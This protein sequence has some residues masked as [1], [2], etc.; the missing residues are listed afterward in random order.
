ML[1]PTLTTYI[2]QIHGTNLSASLVYSA[3]AGA[4]LIARAVF[5]SLMDKIGRKPVLLAGAVVLIATNLLLFAV[6]NIAGICAIRFC[7]GLGWGMASTALATIVSDLVPERRM[8]EGIGYF[9][10]AIVLATSLSI[11][12]GIWLMNFSGFAV[13]LGFST[14]F[15]VVA[16]ALCLPLKVASFHRSQHTGS[17]PGLWSALFEKKAMLP[18]FLCFLHSVAFSGIVTFIMLFGVESGI[19]NVFVYFIGHVLMILVS[20]PIVGRIF[21]RMGHSAVIIP[22]VLSMM[23]GL[24]LL[25][26]S[27]TVPLLVVASLFYGLGFGT[28]QPSL[29]AW[30]IN[31]SPSHRKGAA[32]G[33][34][35]SSIDL[36]YAIGAVL[37]GAIASVTSY[38]VM[39]RLSSLLLVL[40]LAVYV[41]VLMWQKQADSIR[42]NDESAL[43]PSFETDQVQ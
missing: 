24:V 36:G 38:A 3:A 42:V 40:F 16:L 17:A 26:Y 6:S 31:R 41:T 8:G 15:F 1:V 10:L 34:F 27:H 18:A 37:T 4:A 30:A 14:V 12:V 22:G 13:M 43:V 28:V 21:D 39:Y 9:A 33:T 35:L 11:I 32:N 7:Q 2:K 19:R 25:S 29:Q 20:R 5:G 23:I